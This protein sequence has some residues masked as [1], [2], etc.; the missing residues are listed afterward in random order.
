MKTDLMLHTF[1]MERSIFKMTSLRVI[2]VGALLVIS[3][4]VIFQISHSKRAD[5]GLTVSKKTLQLWERAA[6][7]QDDARLMSML[8]PLLVVRYPGTPGY[9]SVQQHLKLTLRN[10]GWEI[11]E[12]TFTD[13]TPLGQK[14]FTNIIASINTKSTHRI[15][16]SAHYESK[17][18]AVCI[19]LLYQNNNT[20]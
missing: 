4:F 19:L 1:C 5:K 9:E 20:S 17:Y 14:Q 10:F 6:A 7:D 18:F 2:A 13:D 8:Q 15:V 11:E 16:V 3:L 12:D